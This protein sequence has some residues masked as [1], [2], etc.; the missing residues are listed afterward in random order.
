MQARDEV[1]KEV[2]IHR[3]ALISYVYRLTGSYEEAKDITQECIL[4]YLTFEK[5]EIINAKAWMFKVATNL[6]RDFLKSA[7]NTKESYIGPWLPEPYMEDTIDTSSDLELDE[8]LSIALMIVIQTLS[9]KERA[10]YILHDILEFK[11]KE[12]ASLLDIKIES[13]RQ[14]SSRANKKIKNKQEPYKV[15]SSK[16]NELSRSFLDAIKTGNLQSLINIFQHDVELHADG[17]GKRSAVKKIIYGDNILIANFLRNVIKKAFK[18]QEKLEFKSTYFNGSLGFLLYY[19]EKLETAY[20]FEV[21]ENKISKIFV[22][23]NPDK[24]E[25]FK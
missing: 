3:K 18:N 14:L 5:E 7:R 12:I 16:H 6:S 24:L 20:S 19:E 8:S 13:S 21:K 22:H 11:H 23:R 1:S 9:I 25:L 15:S 17:G 10:A 2:E 4:K